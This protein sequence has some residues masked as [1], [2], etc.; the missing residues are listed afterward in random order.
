MCSRDKAKQNIALKA[1]TADLFVGFIF[2]M[3]KKRIYDVLSK[4]IFKK[5][6]RIPPVEIAQNR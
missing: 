3:M 6:K 5:I 2:I 4:N 1:I